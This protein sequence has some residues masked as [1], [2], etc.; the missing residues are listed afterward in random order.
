MRENFMNIMLQLS[1]IGQILKAEPKIHSYQSTGA[2]DE[3]VEADNTLTS[4]ISFVL[5]VI[6]QFDNL[7][8]SSYN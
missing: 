5:F 2:T 7:V 1:E 6:S 8:R 3:R 4:N